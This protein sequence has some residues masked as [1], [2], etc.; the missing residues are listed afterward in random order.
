MHSTQVPASA[1]Q[2]SHHA[3][4]ES[5]WRHLVSAVV[6]L[7]H[8]WLFGVG[9]GRIPR[10]LLP[11]LTAVHR[12]FLQ[13]SNV[14]PNRPHHPHPPP[15]R[16]RTAY[17]LTAYTPTPHGPY[18]LHSL[19]MKVVTGLQC[20]PKPPS[21]HTTPTALTAPPPPPHGPYCLPHCLHPHPARRL[22][23][24]LTAVHRKLPPLTA[25]HRKFLQASNQ[26]PHCS[27]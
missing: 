12:K 27:C 18:C 2:C 20:M 14:C 8:P 1:A 16:P 17:C 26:T 7:L 23:P 25:V 19:L 15:L 21:A 24:A 10:P 5:P 11:P 3:L 22:L 13:P 6:H 4:A 9:V